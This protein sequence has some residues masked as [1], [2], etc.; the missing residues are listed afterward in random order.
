MAAISF[1][2][3]SLKESLDRPPGA[4][5]FDLGFAA[6]EAKMLAFTEAIDAYV[7][8]EKEA[9][10]QSAAQHTAT[11]RDLHASKEEMEARIV[12]TRAREREML[13]TIEAERHHLADLTASVGRLHAQLAKI[14]EQASALDGELAGVRREVGLERAVKERQ[15]KIL[16][17]M[18]G[19]DE[20]QLAVLEG[21]LGLKIAGVGDCR[22]LFTFTLI[23]EAKP[24]REFCFVLDVQEEYAIPQ[25]DPPIATGE[26]IAQ[27]NADRNLGAFVRRVRAAFVAHA[28]R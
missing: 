28:A 24:D 21:A 11:V 14:R 16:G 10:S 27:L 26:L 25:C 22:L 17:D 3:V 6:F 19:T 9:I 12:E 2:K 20:A 15:V 18:A 7:L 23:D 5:A 13:D 8:R 4:P 1:P